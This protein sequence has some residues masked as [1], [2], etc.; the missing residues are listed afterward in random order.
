MYV[1]HIYNICTCTCT[2][3][4]VVCWG[5][6]IHV[7]VQVISFY[8]TII[9]YKHCMYTH[10]TYQAIVKLGPIATFGSSYKSDVVCAVL[11]GSVMAISTCVLGLYTLLAFELVND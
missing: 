6:H 1:Y 9:G 4:H 2:C 11:V 3:T 10:C 7:H 8:I 5:L